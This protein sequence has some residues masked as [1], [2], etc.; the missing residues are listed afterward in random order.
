MRCGTDHVGLALPSALGELVD[1]DTATTISG[2]HDADNVTCGRFR[3]ED[4]CRIQHVE[5]PVRPTMNLGARAT[6]ECS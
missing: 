6:A 5:T 3:R 4:A 2:Q 1:G